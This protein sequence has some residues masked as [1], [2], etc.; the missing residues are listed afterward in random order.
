MRAFPC[1]AFWQCCWL[2]FAGF[3][4]SRDRSHQKFYTLMTKTQ[5]FIRFI[6]E[7]SFVSDKDASLAFFDDCV[8][9]VSKSWC[10]YIVELLLLSALSVKV[11]S[12]C[13]W[14]ASGF[15]LLLSYFLI[16]P[17]LLGFIPFFCFKFLNVNKTSWKQIRGANFHWHVYFWNTSLL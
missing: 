6:E 3:L 12:E 17:F 11:Q 2:H 14:N 5:M 1:W 15:L 13:I 8:D 7:C 4:K 9:K 16:L 10:A